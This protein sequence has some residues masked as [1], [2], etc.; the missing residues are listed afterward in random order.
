[1]RKGPKLEKEEN[2]WI[3]SK[4]RNLDMDADMNLEE[5]IVDI[6]EGSGG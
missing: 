3:S 4:R 2:N 5:E 1:M 6:L